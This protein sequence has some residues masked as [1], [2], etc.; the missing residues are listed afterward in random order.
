MVAPVATVGLDQVTPED[1]V[2]PEVDDGD[3]ALVDDGQD[4]ATSM[5]GADLEVMQATGPAQRDPP[6]L[7]ATS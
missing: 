4:P 1:L 2:G 5:G 6:F 7:S 3:L